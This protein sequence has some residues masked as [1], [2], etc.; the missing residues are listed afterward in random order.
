MT[1]DLMKL[2]FA[3]LNYMQ[4]NR[5]EYF[6]FCHGADITQ[7][8][9]ARVMGYDNCTTSRTLLEKISVFV[10]KNSE[11]F[12]AGEEV[13]LKGKLGKKRADRMDTRAHVQGAA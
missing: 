4:Q 12:S 3:I 5:L 10:G 2:R 13:F 1:V 6:A 7:A 8:D 11:E 9:I